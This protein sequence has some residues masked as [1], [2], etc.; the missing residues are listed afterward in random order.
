MKQASQT[1]T[2][3]ISTE[4]IAE[5]QL[6]RNKSIYIIKEANGIE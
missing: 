3:A 2:S 4:N 5:S 6:Q 1:G